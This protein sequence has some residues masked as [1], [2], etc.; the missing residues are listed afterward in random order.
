MRAYIVTMALLLIGCS[1]ATPTTGDQSGEAAQAASSVA[2]AF[3][4]VVRRA[5]SADPKGTTNSQPGPAGWVTFKNVAGQEVTLTTRA[6]P[7]AQR[8][9]GSVG[10][11][12]VKLAPGATMEFP[13]PDGQKLCFSTGDLSKPL[14]VGVCEG[15]STERIAIPAGC[16]RQ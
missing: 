11:Q 10:P 9:D 4:P 14:N 6:Q 16:Y 12:V 1:N 15:R 5:V 2:Q 13:V 8:C 3:P 7:E